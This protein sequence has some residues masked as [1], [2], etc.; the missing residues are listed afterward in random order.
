[1]SPEQ[2]DGQSLDPRSDLF[3]LG[4]VLYECATGKRSFQEKTL[5]A[6]L[7]AVAGHHPPPAHEINP[8]VPQELSALVG[9]LQ[10]KSPAERPPSA[11]SVA[12]SI[13]VIEAGQQ[14]GTRSDPLKRLSPEP[15]RRRSRRFSVG[16]SVSVTI[17]A[18]LWVSFVTFLWK[19]GETRDLS[20]SEKSDIRKLGP[21]SD[22]GPVVPEPRPKPTGLQ[23]LTVLLATGFVLAVIGVLLFDHFRTKAD[24]NPRD[25]Q[26]PADRALTPPDVQNRRYWSSLSRLAGGQQVTLLAIPKTNADDPDTFYVMQDKVSNDLFKAVMETPEARETLRRRLGE[27]GLQTNNPAMKERYIE[28]GQW[29]RGAAVGERDLGVD[30]ERG[31]LP[32]LRVTVLEAQVFAELLGGRIPSVNQWFKAAGKGE[33]KRRGPFVDDPQAPNNFKGIAIGLAATGPRPVGTSERDVSVHG[34]RDFAG[35][36]NEWTRSLVAPFDDREVPIEIRARVPKVYLVGRSFVDDVPLEFGDFEHLGN[37]LYNRA[38]HYIGF[39]IVLEE[40]SSSRP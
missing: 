10:A 29:R 32:V 9:R 19:F 33:G 37:E 23:L 8:D 22:S 36:G 11:H 26:P 28:L 24:W 40:K 21:S 3:S 35:N 38:E 6:I 1:M 39:R 31:K 17:A 27:S 2:A 12:E 4:S 7:A 34:G 30:G 25:W 15:S 18:I 13:Q 5:T 16:C 14:P 20:E